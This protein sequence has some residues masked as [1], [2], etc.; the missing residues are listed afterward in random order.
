MFL[1]VV[2]C[3]NE[4][5]ASYDANRMQ[6]HRWSCGPMQL[7]R[8]VTTV[9]WHSTPTSTDQAQKRC[10]SVGVVAV[11]RSPPYVF[12][13]LQGVTFAVFG[14]SC[15][16]VAQQR[17]CCR[18]GGN[19]HGTHVS[20]SRRTRAAVHV[21]VRPTARGERLLLAHERQAGGGGRRRGRRKKSRKR[22]ARR[23]MSW[24]HVNFPPPSLALA[25]PRTFGA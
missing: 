3:L 4:L 13:K 25:T 22:H 16:V 2:T 19:S 11:C 15:G 14:L 5:P 9:V 18:V 17:T 10:A 8:K 1:H 12:L 23:A 20:D 21:C 7:R 24:R 6:Q